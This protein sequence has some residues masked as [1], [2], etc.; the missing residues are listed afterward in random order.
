MWLLSSRRVRKDGWI[1]GID[2][3]SGRTRD[4]K[5]KV[6][7]SP[8]SGW[9]VV[10]HWNQDEFLK[11]EI[12]KF[13]DAADLPLQNTSYTRLGDFKEKTRTSTPA[14]TMKQ[15]KG[16]GLFPLAAAYEG[17]LEPCA[18]LGLLGS[19]GSLLLAGLAY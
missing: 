3:E 17:A 12:P 9:V 8:P 6:L 7:H 5:V 11:P 1:G 16:P 15:W 4:V 19:L 10:V 2:Y 18:A 13:A 14:L